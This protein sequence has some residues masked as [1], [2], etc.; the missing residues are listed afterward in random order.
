V[1][2]YNVNKWNDSEY[3][4]LK[5]AIDVQSASAYIVHERFYDKLIRLYEEAIPILERT[6]MHWI[7]ANDQIWKKLQPSSVWYCFNTR[8]GKQRPSYSDNS[9]SFQDYNM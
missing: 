9:E 6:G 1:L 8:L 5:K 3:I 2:A 4:F 7:Y